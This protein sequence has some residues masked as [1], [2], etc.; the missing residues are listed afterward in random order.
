MRGQGIHPLEEQ[1]SLAVSI[2][3][4]VSRPRKQINTRLEDLI[5]IM[6]NNICKDGPKVA[7]IRNQKCT[8]KKQQTAFGLP[9]EVA[10]QY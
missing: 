3:N 4:Q 9:L 8:R 2:K 7:Q 10:I 1:A 6:Q 5:A